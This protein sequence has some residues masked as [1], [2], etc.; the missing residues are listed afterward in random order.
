M[1]IKSKILATGLAAMAAYQVSAATDGD[2]A[3][4]ST[5]SIDINFTLGI[6]GVIVDL[7]DFAFGTWSGSGELRDNDDLC[8]GTTGTSQYIIRADGDGAGNS[9]TLS[10][11][12]A[13]LPYRVFWNDDIGTAGN[14]ELTAGVQVENLTNPPNAFQS[15][16][17]GAYICTGDRDANVEIVIDEAALQAAEAGSYSG[18]LTLTMIPQ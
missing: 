7:R 4:T 12:S 14:F 3:A 10:N 16:G 13:N 5:G 8:I 1:G 6:A 2:L 9:F 17:G 15:I 18:V 11:G